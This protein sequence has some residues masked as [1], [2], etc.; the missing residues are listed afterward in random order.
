MLAEMNHEVRGE[1][2]HESLEQI[3]DTDPEYLNIFTLVLACNCSDKTLSLLS[4]RLESAKTPLL[5]V[6]TSGF[7]GYIRLQLSEHVVVET[8]PDNVS[9][10]LRLDSAWPELVTWL[11]SESERMESMDL[12]DHSHTPYPVIIYR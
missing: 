3:L 11:Q 1:T 2:R 8:H 7:F 6:R 10:D 9:P 5:V 12:K 4:S